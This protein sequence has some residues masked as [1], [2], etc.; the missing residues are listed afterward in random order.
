[1]SYIKTTVNSLSK[2]IIKLFNKEHC[3]L[4]LINI[5]SL[6]SRVQ[7]KPTKIGVP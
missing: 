7:R 1:M 6:D 3:N 5:L 4:E 2:A